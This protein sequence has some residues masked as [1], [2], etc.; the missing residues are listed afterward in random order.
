MNIYTYASS[1]IK[2]VVILCFIVVIA[3]VCF[4]GNSVVFGNTP[5][6]NRILID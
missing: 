6:L 1:L 5:S 3:V 4:V 2:T